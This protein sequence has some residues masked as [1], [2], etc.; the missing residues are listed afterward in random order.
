MRGLFN[1]TVPSEETAY[2]QS[3]EIKK[4]SHF[5]RDTDSEVQIRDWFPSLHPLEDRLF[6]DPYTQTCLTF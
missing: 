5:T 1:G 4:P 6:P 2:P 3:S